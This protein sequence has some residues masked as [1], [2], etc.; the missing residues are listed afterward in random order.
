MHFLLRYLEEQVKSINNNSTENRII[1]QDIIELLNIANAT[2]VK[3]LYK[4]TQA[5]II[6]A[7]TDII[8]IKA[9]LKADGLF[10]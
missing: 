4:Q 10:E 5:D 2:A 9:Q 3:M 8:A 6:D 7:E 1:E